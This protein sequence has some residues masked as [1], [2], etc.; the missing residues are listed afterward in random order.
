MYRKWVLAGAATLFIAPAHA[1][2]ISVSP[3]GGSSG[4][5]VIN[6]GCADEL[7]GPAAT[8][9]GCLNNNHTSSGDVNFY[10][11][12]SVKFGSGGGQ[13]VVKATDGL[14]STLTLDPMN[15]LLSELIVDVNASANGFIDFCDNVNCSAIFTVDKNG[16]NFFD[17]T[18]NP[19]ADFLTLNTFSDALG[20]TSAQLIEDTRQW[21][22][23]IA[24][25]PPCRT[26]CGPPPSVPEPNT[27]WVLGA[28]LLAIGAFGR[29]RRRL[30]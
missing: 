7:D 6:N 25:Q 24:G 8:I 30:I 28:G 10:S 14:T 11:N 12:E 3:T 13:A 17:I 19:A 5:L 23:V 26:N 21:R 16:S 4:V 18:F 15:F 20:Q 9:T 27:L 22:L 1:T 2:I 29:V